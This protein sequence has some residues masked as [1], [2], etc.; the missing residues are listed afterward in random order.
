VPG[1][2]SLRDVLDAESRAL[3]GGYLQARG[4]LVAACDS[5]L[6]WSRP[7]TA[8][9]VRT[10]VLAGALALPSAAVVLFATRAPKA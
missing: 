1:A 2:K 4:A 5:L 3:F 9:R 7:D 6:E 8:G 10:R